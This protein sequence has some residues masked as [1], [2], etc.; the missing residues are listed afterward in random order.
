MNPW[1][2]NISLW[3]GP[4]FCGLAWPNWGRL[5]FAPW[6]KS[7]HALKEDLFA[8]PGELWAFPLQDLELSEWNFCRSF[9]SYS[10]VHLGDLIKSWVNAVS[11]HPWAMGGWEL[12]ASLQLWCGN[13]AYVAHVMVCNREDGRADVKCFAIRKVFDS[14]RWRGIPAPQGQNLE[15]QYKTGEKEAVI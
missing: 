11:S 14:V 12:V 1:F 7:T 2:C 15:Q 3:K 9:L 4:C 6:N 8:N 13:W 10:K 5:V